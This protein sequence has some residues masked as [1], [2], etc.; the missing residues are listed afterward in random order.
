MCEFATPM[1]TTGA[2]GVMPLVTDPIPVNK[3]V[4]KR[5][6]MKSLRDYIKHKQKQKG[7]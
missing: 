3:P 7:F 2:G 6:K 4:K 5:K 1:N